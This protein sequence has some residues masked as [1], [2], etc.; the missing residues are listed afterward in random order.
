MS[1]NNIPKL[2][3]IESNPM[4]H[5]HEAFFENLIQEERLL[6]KEDI[7]NFLNV[8]IK[9]IDRLVSMEEIPFYK[10]GRSVRFSK[11]G[12]LAWIKETNSKR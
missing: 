5:Y 9:K 10:I 6:T 7:A 4:S 1:K 2:S 8:S 3:S 12:V 11:K